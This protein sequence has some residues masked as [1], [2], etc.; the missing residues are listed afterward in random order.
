MSPPD[1][2]FRIDVEHQG[3]SYVVRIAGELDLSGCPDLDAALEVAE[4]TQA[5][6]IILDMEGL[7][8]IDS[9]GLRTLLE[10]SHRSARNGNRLQMTRATGH[11][12][13]LFQLTGLDEM[14][15]LVGPTARR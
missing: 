3:D 15:P 1:P 13:E 9:I 8:F 12:A 7:T 4:Q 10:A 2:F 14:L 6:Q 11:P 5:G